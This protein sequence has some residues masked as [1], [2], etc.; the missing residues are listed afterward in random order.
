MKALAA[1]VMLMLAASAY[2][3]K[4]STQDTLTWISTHFETL[5]YTGQSNGPHRHIITTAMAFSSCTV[6]S[7]V[8]THTTDPDSPQPS[9]TT[10][11]FSF[12]L[13][14]LRPEKIL[15]APGVVVELFYV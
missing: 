13:S 1:T 10:F 7:L 8:E 14:A 15:L 6:T 12:D 4:P 2:A 11:T 9:T 5:D 3:Q